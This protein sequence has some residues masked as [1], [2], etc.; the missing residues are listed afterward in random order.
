M[1][2]LCW[3]TDRSSALEKEIKPIKTNVQGGGVEL[4]S[5]WDTRNIQN[6]DLVLSAAEVNKGAGHYLGN[7]GNNISVSV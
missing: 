2:W 7:E 1:A 4:A 6:R 3:C 5:S